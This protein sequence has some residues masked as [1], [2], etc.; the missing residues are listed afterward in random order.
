MLEL[1]PD[2]DFLS[3]NSNRT[4]SYQ[5]PSCSRQSSRWK[6]SSTSQQ[7]SQPLLQLLMRYPQQPPVERLW[8]QLYSSVG[9]DSFLKGQPDVQRRG[10]NQ[11]QFAT[12]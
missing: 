11:S 3:A 1:Q 5:L 12:S 2:V 4:L 8:I 7:T 6:P 10:R 9:T